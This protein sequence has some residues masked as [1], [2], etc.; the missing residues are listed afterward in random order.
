MG[1]IEM[2]EKTKLVTSDRRN[3]G[4]PYLPEP[5]LNPNS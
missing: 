4:N 3:S 2:C 1:R 5:Q